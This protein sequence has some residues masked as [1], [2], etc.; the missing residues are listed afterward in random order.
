MKCWRLVSGVLFEKTKKDVVPEM[1]AMIANLN[2]VSK[3]IN[4]TLVALKQE[5]MQCEKSYES[6]MAQAKLRNNA[7]IEGNATKS[8]GVL[9]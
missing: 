4:S 6:I 9:V 7:Q 8:G 1:R 5:M 3:Q 2:Q